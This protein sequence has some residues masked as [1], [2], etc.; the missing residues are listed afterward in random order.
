MR[1]S[2]TD[3]MQSLQEGMLKGLLGARPAIWVDLQ[4]ALEK[5]EELCVFG[6]NP[7][8]KRCL[9]GDENMI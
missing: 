1:F 2:N 5:V 7:I 6:S 8:A 3:I 4:Q 9:F